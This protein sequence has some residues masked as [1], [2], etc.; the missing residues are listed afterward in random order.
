[1]NLIRQEIL[2]RHKA[3]L[4]DM[5]ALWYCCSMCNFKAKRAGSLRM[6]VANAH[7]IDV[8]WQHC[9]ICEYKAK[10]ASTLKVHKRISMTSMWR[11]TIATTNRAV[12]K[13]NYGVP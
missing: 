13:Q 9:D 7:D 5:D 2:I 11:G 10:Q 8:V 3:Q 1:M 12:I 4:H 6:H